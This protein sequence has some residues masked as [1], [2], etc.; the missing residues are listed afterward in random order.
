M[1]D[2][3]GSSFQLLQSG[4]FIFIR[5]LFLIIGLVLIVVAFYFYDQKNNWLDTT[6]K[7]SGKITELV[8]TKDRKGKI[9]YRPTYTFTVNNELIS[10]ASKV[11]STTPSFEVDDS[12]E[13]IYNKADARD[14]VIGSF[15]ELWILPAIFGIVG[16][17]LTVFGGTVFFFR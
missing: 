14:A 12:V 2:K 5:G 9:Y 3:K 13:V 15:W 17:L 6:T 8:A 10:V 16:T 4:V 11:S 7:T 1:I